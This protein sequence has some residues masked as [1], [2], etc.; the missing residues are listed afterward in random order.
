M[1]QKEDVDKS[2]KQVNKKCRS[3]HAYIK[4]QALFLLNTMH[5]SSKQE[6]EKRLY[7]ACFVRYGK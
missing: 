1:K 5:F 2:K 4:P 3:V 6:K 7:S